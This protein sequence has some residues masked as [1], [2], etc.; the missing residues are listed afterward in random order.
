MKHGGY[1]YVALAACGCVRGCIVDSDVLERADVA[2]AVSSWI[3]RDLVIERWPI[4][5]VRETSWR[6]GKDTCPFH[7]SENQLELTGDTP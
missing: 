7:A 3:R 1:T 4:E 6:C 2:S 5:K